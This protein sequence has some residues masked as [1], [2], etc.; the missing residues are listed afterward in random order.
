MKYII[1]N[2]KF[3]IFAIGVSIV[4]VFILKWEYSQADTY[5]FILMGVALLLALIADK[6]GHLMQ[7]LA[8]DKLTRNLEEVNFKLKESEKKFRDFFEQSNVPMAIFNLKAL[9]FV[10]AND[11]L[12]SLLEYTNDEI[13]SMELDQLIYKPDVEGSIEAANMNVNEQKLDEYTNRYITKSG[14]IIKL[15]WSF[16]KGDENGLSS[17]VALLLQ[18]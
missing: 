2:N 5:L 3:L 11:T 8:V 10:E 16:T 6:V 12:C 1:H 17:C 14:K 15:R 18:G 4:N 7:F 13:C 9:R